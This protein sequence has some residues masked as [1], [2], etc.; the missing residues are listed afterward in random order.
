MPKLSPEEFEAIIE[1]QSKLA[2]YDVVTN[3]LRTLPEDCDPDLVDRL[4]KENQGMN[5]I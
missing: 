4:V 1:K 3:L 2:E 5:N